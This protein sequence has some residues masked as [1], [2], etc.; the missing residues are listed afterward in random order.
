MSVLVLALP[1]ALALG[2][3]A[4]WACVTCIRTGQ[5]DDLD[6]PPL[7]ILTDDLPQ[8]PQSGQADSQNQSEPIKAAP[9]STSSGSWT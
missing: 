6:T 8:P 7:R 9:R 3:L 1:L 4:L 2:G 5:F